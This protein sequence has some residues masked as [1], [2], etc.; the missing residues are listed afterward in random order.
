MKK[1]ILA[2]ALTLALFA[3]FT[4]TSPSVE[5]K[6]TYVKSYYK[7]S[8][9]KYVGGHYKTSADRTKLNNYSSKG[10]TNPFTGK[11]GSVKW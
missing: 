4:V 5:A 2:S 3:G 8:T 11:K 1:L 10:N 9:G 7:P 6:T